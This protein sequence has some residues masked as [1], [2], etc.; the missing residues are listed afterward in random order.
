MKKNN[1]IQITHLIIIFLLILI[2]FSIPYF[3]YNLNDN[4]NENN[5][6]NEN[7][8]LNENNINENNNFNKEKFYNSSINYNRC[9]NTGDKLRQLNILDRI[10]NPI[11][12][13]YQSM[14]FYNSVEYDNYNLPD[15]VIGC[16]RRRIPCIGGSQKVINNEIPCRKFTDDNI[17][18]INIRT[19]GPEGQPQQVGTLYNIFSN[20]NEVLPLFGRK[21][22]P[23][24]NKWEYYAIAGQFGSK[25]P[26]KPL[27]NYDEIGTNDMVQLINYPGNFRATIY[28]KDS[29]QYIPYV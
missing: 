29:P 28:E 5:N 25:I 16:G 8:N 9:D 11:R 14:P 12:Y 17:A 22:F 24:D 1:N 15:I 26:V 27:R 23:N 19:Q 6:I 20:K 21:R 10:Y 18:P 13:P 7:I 4:I 2:L 3:F